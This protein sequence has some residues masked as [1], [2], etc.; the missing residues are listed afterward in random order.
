MTAYGFTRTIK[1]MLLELHEQEY[2]S[3]FIKV[4]PV[5]PIFNGD[6]FIYTWQAVEE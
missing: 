6:Y 4:A 5:F 1:R 3:G 2:V